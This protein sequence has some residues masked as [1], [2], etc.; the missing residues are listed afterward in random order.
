MS[1]VVN[2]MK[3]DEIFSSTHEQLTL[4]MIVTNAIQQTTIKVTGTKQKT[5]LQKLTL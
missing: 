2:K 1:C 5:Q 3:D 4:C